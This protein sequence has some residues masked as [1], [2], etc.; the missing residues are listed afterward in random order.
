MNG[1]LL[2]NVTTMVSALALVLGIFLVILYG[3]TYFRG[4]GKRGKWIKV[5]AA[6]DVGSKRTIALVEVVDEVLVLG[7]APQH[8]SLLSKVE[9]P[10]ALRRL[11]MAE[12][13]QPTHSFLDY[14]EPML[15]KRR[16]AARQAPATKGKEQTHA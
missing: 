4:K 12:P 6:T 2:S 5:L 7:L 3:A 13:A 8:I 1:E 11:N 16:H 15:T 9:K 14:L 10:E